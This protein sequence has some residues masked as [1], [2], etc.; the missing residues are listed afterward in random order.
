MDLMPLTLVGLEITRDVRRFEPTHHFPEV[1]TPRKL[2]ATTPVSPAPGAQRRMVGHFAIPLATAYTRVPAEFTAGW[3]LRPLWRDATDFKT[4]QPRHSPLQPMPVQP[5]L[6]FARCR[7]IIPAASE[8]SF[9]RC[10]VKRCP[11]ASPVGILSPV[12]EAGMR[13]CGVS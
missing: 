13:D 6:L 9:A 2:S 5:A 3:P 1:S 10:E 4:G 12:T 7:V 8:R 11:A